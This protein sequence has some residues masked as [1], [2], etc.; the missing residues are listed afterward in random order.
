MKYAFLLLQA[1]V[2][3]AGH[4]LSAE[5]R[6]K[7][8]EDARR[9]ISRALPYVQSKGQEWID[10]RGCVS[11]HQVPS[12]L[13]GLHLAAKLGWDIDSKKL[14]ELSEWSV[15]WRHWNQSGES[16]GQKLVA[17]A[18]TAT[19]AFLILAMNSDGASP[20][21]KG[22]TDARRLNKDW[23]NGFRAQLLE[24]QQ[25]DGS[26]KAGGQ[27]PLSK[28]P[29]RENDEVTTLWVL[30]ALK[31][32]Y[33]DPASEAALTKAREQATA[34][35]QLA[36]HAGQS[37]EWHVAQCLLHPEDATLHATLLSL[38]H[39]DGSW[40][41]LAKEPGGAFGTG[42]ALYALSRTGTKTPEVK[43]AATKALNFL[44]QTQLDDGSWSVPSTRGRD[45]NKA[46]P[47]S[48]YWGTAWAMI[49]M[50]EW[51]ARQTAAP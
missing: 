42:L 38:Q 26:W 10:D 44:R 24:H 13:W 51:E 40:G 15:D 4:A 11:C 34:F 30:L 37:T 6:D 23:I 47:T 50:L 8:D 9:V 35:I 25:Q 14:A 16:Q 39:P 20:D 33:A 49:G 29:A 32:T 3:V 27:L 43:N 21:L 41:W 45:H 18:N 31:E 2:L 22:E 5:P 46:I 1:V 28:R 7:E 19:M 12:M 48:N 17:A 36:P